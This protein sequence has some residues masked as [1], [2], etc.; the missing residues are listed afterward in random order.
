MYSLWWPKLC[1]RVELLGE[2]KKEYRSHG[3]IVQSKSKHMIYESDFLKL[4]ISSSHIYVDTQIS[5][6][7]SP[8]PPYIAIV[9]IPA[10]DQ[11]EIKM[12][13]I[14]SDALC[15]VSLVNQDREKNKIIAS[16]LPC[17]YIAS[18]SLKYIFYF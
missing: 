11:I 6:H 13:E 14:T 7:S 16:P 17:I 1:L 9:E 18:W 10:H 2:C 4:P 12:S 3:L 5:W 8:H 15:S